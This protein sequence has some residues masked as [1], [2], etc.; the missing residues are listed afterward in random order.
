MMSIT[1]TPLP[2]VSPMR[3]AVLLGIPAAVAL[4]CWIYLSVMVVDMAA[5]PGMAAMV[6][7]APIRLFGLFVMWTVMMAAMMLPTAAPMTVTYARMHH[8]PGKKPAGAWLAVLMSAGGYVAAWT[9]FSA[10][11]T[12][13]QAVATDLALLSPM[14]MKLASGPIAGA[15]LIAAGIYQWL[16][17][18]HACLKRCRSPIGFLMTEWRE[19]ATGAFAMGWRHGLFCIGCCAALMALL[20]VAGVMNAFWIIALTVYVLIEKTVPHGELLTKAVGV[21]L[22]GAGA[23]L[24]AG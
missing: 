20:F 16:P 18:K 2:P 10:A 21:G 24:I 15:V 23:W 9:A 8:R 1:Q 4:A 11:A 14:A 17:V 22:V 3:L 19:G 7:Y 6:P 5:M 13:L 12:V